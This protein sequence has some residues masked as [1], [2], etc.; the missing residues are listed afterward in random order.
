M[1]RLSLVTLM[2]ALALS[3]CAAPPPSGQAQADTA[4]RNACR[5]R[6]DETYN[7]QK[8]GDIYRPQ[9]PVNTP[10]S[11]GYTPGDTQTGLSDLFAYDRMV[12]DCVRNTGTETERSPS[13]KS[14]SPPAK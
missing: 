1:I 12:N 10:Y 3:A 6:A 2:G 11:A 9:A 13:A 7:L 8:R 14:P 5:Q 4:T